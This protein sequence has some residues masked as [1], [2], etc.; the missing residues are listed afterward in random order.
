MT[1]LQCRINLA[2]KARSLCY[3]PRAFKGPALPMGVFLFFFL[4]K[5]F[6]SLFF[7]FFLACRFFA[8]GRMQ[9]LPNGGGGA[10]PEPQSRPMWQ[11]GGANS[12]RGGA[13]IQAL[14]PGRWRPSLRYCLCRLPFLPLGDPDQY[15][16]VMQQVDSAHLSH[17][18]Y[19]IVSWPLNRDSIS[20]ITLS[21]LK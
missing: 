3:G 12:G 2:A 17:L 16:N 13:P 11:G 19:Q 8:M 20:T 1:S 14:A 4:L 21:R 6:F 7:F 9:D 15:H 10:H 5:T 18:T